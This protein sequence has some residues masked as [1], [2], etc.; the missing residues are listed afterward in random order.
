MASFESVL[1]K[2][3]SQVRTARARLAERSNLDPADRA[4]AAAPGA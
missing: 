3:S 4:K 2:T 1:H